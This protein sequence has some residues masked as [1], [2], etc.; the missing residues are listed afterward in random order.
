[1]NFLEA[2]GGP[3]AFTYHYAGNQ[4]T[5]DLYVFKPLIELERCSLKV[6]PEGCPVCLVT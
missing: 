1:M 2:N 5:Y 6:S 3:C 4:C